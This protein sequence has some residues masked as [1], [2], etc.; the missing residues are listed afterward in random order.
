VTATGAASDLAV[1]DCFD[2]PDVTMNITDVRHQSC[3]DPHDGE[4][5][6]VLDYR[7]EG[8]S[9]SY[10]ILDTFR[11]FVSDNCVPA[12]ESYT[13]RTTDEIGAAGFSFA[14]LYPS[15]E[16]WSEGDREV[17][18]YI[19]KEDETKFAGT[20]RRADDGSTPSAT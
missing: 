1:G 19:S 14:Y 15:L 8:G 6:A 9:T 2:E 10:P 18:C 12:L 20:L 16:S 11:E 5:F 13:G 3:S 4:V 7:L 17:T